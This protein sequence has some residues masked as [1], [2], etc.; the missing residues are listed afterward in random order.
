V[1]SQGTAI[2]LLAFSLACTEGGADPRVLRTDSAGVRIVASRGS[3]WAEGTEW[4]VDSEPQLDLAISGT[5]PEYEFFRVRNAARLRDGLIAVA[6]G[7]TQEV[8]L[9]SSSGRFLRVF[10]R[11]GEGP[12]EFQRLTSVHQVRGDSLLAFDYWERRVTVFDLEDGGSR[13]FAIPAMNMLLQ[14]V[15]PLADGT[16]VVLGDVVEQ[17]PADGLY[18]LPADV[19]LIDLTGSGLDTVA[20]VRGHEGF[21]FQGGDARPLF[22]KNG[23][24]AARGDRIYVGSGDSMEIAVYRRTQ[25]L[26]MVVRVPGYDLRL[27]PEELKAERGALRPRPGSPPV[28]FEVAAALPDPAT[29]P[30]YSAL[31]I[32]PDGFVFAPEYHGITEGDRATAVAVFDPEGEWLGFV[33]LP[34]RFVPHE[35]GRQDIL[36]VFTDENGVEHVQLL[37]LNRQAG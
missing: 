14:R 20:R 12:G 26:E 9:F 10:G 1:S 2:G 27:T 17:A 5:G 11:E 24:I 16:L 32:D 15:A 21:Q 37:R 31:L 7:G 8:R 13:T 4:S 6:N 29:R 23:R 30:A 28:L 18:R 34:P 35:I 33:R 25:G 22:S 19:V 3:R 36:G